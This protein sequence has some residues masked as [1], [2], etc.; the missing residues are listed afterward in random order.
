V[1]HGAP[2]ISAEE[3]R[4]HDGEEESGHESGQGQAGP[5]QSPDHE[6]R[7]ASKGL[8]ARGSRFHRER[9]RGDAGAF[10]FARISLDSRGLA[11]VFKTGGAELEENMVAGIIRLA[12]LVL[13]IYSTVAIV[14][15]FSDRPG[16]GTVAAVMGLFGGLLLFALGRILADLFGRKKTS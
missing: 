10:P 14:I 4:Q 9:P 11:R 13:S 7:A 5:G 2:I 8:T 15:G 6:T 12:G 1:R 3:D 16:G